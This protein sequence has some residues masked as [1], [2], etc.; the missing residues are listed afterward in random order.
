MLVKQKMKI[1]ALNWS[2]TALHTF[3][4]L[5]VDDKS[6]IECPHLVVTFDN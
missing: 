6:R 1:S 3:Y 5:A 4:Y 2:P